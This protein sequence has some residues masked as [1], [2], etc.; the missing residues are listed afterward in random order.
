MFKHSFVILLAYTE[1]FQSDIL[2][3]LN[4]SIVADESDIAL[5]YYT[6]SGS[7]DS[8]AELKN[9]LSGNTYL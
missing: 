7:S 6:V 2:D 8:I 1:N 4:L 3:P 5:G 9:Y